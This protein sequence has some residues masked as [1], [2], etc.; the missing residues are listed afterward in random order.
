MDLNLL[1]VLDALL[2]ESSVAGAAR[3]LGRSQPA[4]SHSLRHL[5]LLFGDQLLVRVGHRMLLTPRAEAMRA[6]LREVI[7]A[8]SSLL[9]PAEFNPSTSARRFRLMMPE[10]VA[11]MI[12]PGLARRVAREAPNIVLDLVS[13]RGAGLITDDF[14]RSIDLIISW[15]EHQFPGFHRHRLYM[16]SDALAF[17]VGHPAAGSLSSLDGFLAATH[18]A[19]IG[20]GETSDPIDEWLANRKLRRRIA[21][22]V[23]NYV[24]AL[25]VA[26]S[27]DHIAFAPGRTIDAL[28]GRLGLHRCTPPLDPGYDEQMIF[29]PARSARDPASIW[30][31]KAILEEG[32]SLAFE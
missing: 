17:R 30:L 16:D 15:S 31:R 8:A 26:A 4:V 22:T 20:A 11:S 5:R 27:T 6:P 21:L 14:A 23:G 28:S 10:F 3:R 12:L 25:Q 7:D 24:Q 32:K 2:S 1:V 19:V 18:I 29:F 13:W 9:A